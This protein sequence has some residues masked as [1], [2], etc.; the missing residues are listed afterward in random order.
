[1]IREIRLLRLRILLARAHGTTLPIATI[2]IAIAP[3]RNRLA[4]K[5]NIAAFAEAMVADEQS[6]IRPSSP[7]CQPVPR[8]S[9]S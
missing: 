2:G 6:A 4:S 3:W 8:K 1:V 9:R 5:D 7:T